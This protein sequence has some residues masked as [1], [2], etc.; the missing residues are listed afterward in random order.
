M[1]DDPNP[2]PN[3]NAIVTEPD[4]GGTD[5]V[6]KLPIFHARVCCPRL[7]QT[8]VKCNSKFHMLATN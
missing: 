4:G 1:T 3:L 7:K 2:D 5:G 8:R 6:A